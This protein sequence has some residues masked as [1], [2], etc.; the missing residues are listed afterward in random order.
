MWL[1]ERTSGVPDIIAVAEPAPELTFGER[2]TLKRLSTDRT[3]VAIRV[4]ISA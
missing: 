1:F 3:T 4:E 2:E